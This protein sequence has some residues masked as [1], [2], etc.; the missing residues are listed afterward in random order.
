MAGATRLPRDYPIAGSPTPAFLI[1]LGVFA[2]ILLELTQR[3]THEPAAALAG[4]VILWTIT[5]T[6]G[7]LAAVCLLAL[8]KLTTFVDIRST[9]YRRD[10]A[11]CHGPVAN[12]TG[13]AG[14]QPR[15]EDPLAVDRR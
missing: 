7:S 2:F 14:Q 9:G 15:L 13:R 5:T 3:R 6:G 10:A 12:L 11:D 1:G 8:C 4:V